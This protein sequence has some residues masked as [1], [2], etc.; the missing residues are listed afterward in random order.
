VAL[1]V[2]RVEQVPVPLGFDGAVAVRAV[3][4]H[5]VRA[6]VDDDDRLVSV[7]VRFDGVR[8]RLP[9][10]VGR[11]HRQDALAHRPTAPPPLTR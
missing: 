6:T 9:V 8:C 2:V 7:G 1:F 3:D 11:Y 4:A 5:Q 10:R